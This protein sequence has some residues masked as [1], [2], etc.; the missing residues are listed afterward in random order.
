M[1]IL[2]IRFSS[3]GDIVLT[4]PVVRCL[5]E[6]M[7][8]AEIHFLTKAKFL[9]IPEGNPYI[10]KV[11][12]LQD[13]LPECIRDLRKEKFDHIVDLHKNLRTFIVRFRLRVSVTSF[14][15]LNLQKWLLVN[16]K[17]NRLP[18]LH[19]VDRYFDAVKKFQI[20]NDQKG[21]NYF[22]PEESRKKAESYVSTFAERFCV[23]ALAG[24]WFTKR[25]PK[26]KTVELINQLAL[27]VVLLGGMQEKTDA[28]YIEQH[29]ENKVLNLCGKLTLNESAAVV[30]LS[31]IVFLNDTGLMHIASAFKKKT[32]SFWGSNVPAFGMYPYHKDHY[33]GEVKGLSCRPCSKL[34]KKKCPKG[35]FK[36]MTDID[37]EAI[38]QW[39]SK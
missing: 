2:I 12:L 9:E 4:T 36:C 17:I 24:T 26:E 1:K 11:H 23:F 34:G 3:I 32:V 38:L 6:Q 13:S 7:P 27:P 25:Y 33:L 18:E 20:S 28:E 35:H 37:Q 30:S 15:K 10:D 5:K 29:T 39:I 14:P 21:L 31:E 22:I 16:F 8:D 19:I